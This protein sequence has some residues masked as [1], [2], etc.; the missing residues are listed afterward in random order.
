[1]TTTN[2]GPGD[3]V[4][5][6]VTGFV[7]NAATLGGVSIPG[8]TTTG[9]VCRFTI[10]AVADG[11]YLPVLSSL[12]KDIVLTDGTLT[13]GVGVIL[14]FTT[15]NVFPL[16]RTINSLRDTIGFQLSQQGYS[17]NTS[18][19][20]YVTTSVANTITPEGGIIGAAN[21]FTA[22]L[23]N[24]TTNQVVE[25]PIDFVPINTN[26]SISVEDWTVQGSSPAIDGNN[27]FNTRP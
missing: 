10:P 7:P 24:G 27:P 17:V 16:T 3:L 2:F 6:P 14:T 12:G 20:V 22:Y 8:V 9:G 21:S 15:H 1:M 5:I 4:E 26:P 18:D 19:L 25:L 11:N 23:H 13:D